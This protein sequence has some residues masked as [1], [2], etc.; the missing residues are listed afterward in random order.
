MTE[1]T[2]RPVGLEWVGWTV[3]V[4][5][6]GRS[7]EQEMMSRDGGVEDVD[8][9][10]TPNGDVRKKKRRLSRSEPCVE[11]R[12]VHVYGKEDDDTKRDVAAPGVREVPPYPPDSLRKM[13]T[14]LKRKKE[15]IHEMENDLRRIMQ[16]RK[17]I[18]VSEYFVLLKPNILKYKS[19]LS[20]ERKGE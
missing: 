16:K 10:R 6:E 14:K 9:E 20:A 4:R 2:V 3:L 19:I 15:M 17:K 7:G 5:E 18:E 11:V 8:L 1:D 12:L 13:I